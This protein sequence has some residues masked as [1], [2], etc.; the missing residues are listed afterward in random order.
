MARPRWHGGGR[1][2]WGLLLPRE[3][4]SIQLRAP[5]TSAAVTDSPPAPG[6]ARA[7]RGEEARRR[8]LDGQE[9]VHLSQWQVGALWVEAHFKHL[10]LAAE[11]VLH[12]VQ[13]RT[14]T[15]NR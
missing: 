6:G 12:V 3:G 4:Q 2:T 1:G 10:G 8:Y 11:Q 15:L 13:L 14:E 7:Q 9:H 5:V